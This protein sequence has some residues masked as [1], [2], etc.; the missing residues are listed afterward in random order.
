MG[1]SPFH[2]GYGSKAIFP[3]EIMIPTSRSKCVKQGHI[4]DLLIQDKVILDEI[5]L[6]V[7]KH[8]LKY[9]E[10]INKRYSKKLKKG[11]LAGRLGAQKSCTLVRSSKIG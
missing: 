2:L 1:P 7:V 11:I 3:M 5:R 10:E 6:E 4:N 8:T 9:Q